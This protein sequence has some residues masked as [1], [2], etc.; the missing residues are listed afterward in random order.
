ML[1]PG[2]GVLH[3][4]RQV[5]SGL[6]LMLLLRGRV[7]DTTLLCARKTL[8]NI[9]HKLVRAV[10]ELSFEKHSLLVCE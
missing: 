1:R 3:Q 4:L 7:N 6:V 9:H 10:V 5:L 8:G 2:I